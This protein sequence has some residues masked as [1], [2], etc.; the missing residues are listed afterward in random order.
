MRKIYCFIGFIM[1]AGG[2][3]ANAFQ[4]NGS[5]IKGK[6]TDLNG[7]SLPGA[8]VTIENTFL[9]IHTDADGK[10]FFKGLKDG[11][12]ALRFS[13][14]GFE[15]QV[16]EV[17]L[18]EEEILNISLSP[19][20]FIT[21]E[22][23]VNA[24]R[25]GEHTPLAY[26]TVN[27]ELLKK[28]N[29]GPDLPYLLS[30]TPSLVETSEAGNGV[31]Y[32]SLRVR[33]TDGS[34]INVTIDGIPLNDPESQ[35]VFWVDLPDLASSIENI[36]VQRGVGTSSNG[37]GAFGATIS[38]QTKNPENEPFAEV[39]SSVGSFNTTKNMVSAG[40]GLLSGKFAVQMRYSDLK[41][42][43]FIE[44]T[45]SDHRSA[46]IS[47][48]FKTDRSRLKANII[49]GEEHTGIS[50]WGVPKEMLSVNRRYNPAGEYTDEGGNTCYYN[51]ET[52]NYTQNHYQLIYS[53][54]LNNELSLNTALHY[55]KG[56]GYYEEYKDDATLSGYGLPDMK[57][58]DIIIS[59]TDLIRRKWMSNDFYGL[60]YSLKYRK[61]KIDATVGGGLNYY[62][63]DHYG[64]IIWMQYAGNTAK[65]HQWYLNNGTKWELSL[66]GKV[67]YSLTDKT[68]I[69]GDLQYRYINYN[70]SGADD[71]FKDLSQKF[72][73]N[74]FNPKAGIF[75]SI[76]P[77]RDAYFS[78]SVANREPTRSDYKEAAGDADATP[79]PETLYN[80]EIGYKQ[81]RG[82]SSFSI[83]IY[84]MIY[85]DQLVPTGQLSNVG[86]SIMT[87]VEKS[88]RTGVEISAGFKPLN[89]LDWDLGLTISRNKILDFIEYYVDYNTSDWSEE[90]KSKEHGSVDIAYSPS[91]TGISDMNFKILPNTQ[92]H[93]ISKYVGKQYFDNTMNHDRMI[94][95]YFV[96]NIRLDYE[97]HIRNVKGI[98][99]QLLVNNVFNE[100]YE[101]N[102]YGGNWYED[103]SEK[104]WSYYFPQAGI[105]YMF[106]VGVKF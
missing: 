4:E 105:N 26:S 55:T 58:G 71:D 62:S 51:N 15:T 63:G 42:D 53:L 16:R 28:Q 21:E 11:T 96:N 67:N 6:V 70:M 7:K 10:Y 98:E 2:I 19:M 25:A 46:Y 48:I 91:F 101:S 87:N 36:Q 13:F 66:Y 9:G 49:L 22:V 100:I 38:I 90:Y 82:K 29:M 43:G 79:R 68:T 86:Y 14:I 103:G 18:K 23:F 81:R 92:I 34:R 35:Q 69:F 80:T 3:Q 97:P 89:F 31:G 44:R 102:A 45:G 52:D 27:Q 75:Y 17:S 30:L 106:K 77:N 76:D 50:W 104:S 54:K 47:G 65:D 37:A 12:Y 24:I 93:L 39:N 40:T 84:G 60:V 83:N 59:G 73:F 74:F 32:T 72:D 56:K 99:F 5:A 41:S 95:P 57:I 94:D 61:E 85:K 78:F 1:L 33:G 88:Y 64:R 20:T 8:S